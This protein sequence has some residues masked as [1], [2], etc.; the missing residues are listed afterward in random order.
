MQSH[1]YASPEAFDVAANTY[2]FRSSTSPDCYPLAQPI[3][4]NVRKSLCD[5]I[6]V[7]ASFFFGMR[8]MALIL[9]GGGGVG[10]PS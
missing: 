3:Y 5:H 7:P 9:G 8:T 6:Q 10:V 1:V 2:H 4:I